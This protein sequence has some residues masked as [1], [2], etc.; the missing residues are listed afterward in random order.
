MARLTDLPVVN[1]PLADLLD[2][3]NFWC[4]DVVI[5]AD[6]ANTVD[7]EYGPKGAVDH[8]LEPGKSSI[9][10]ARNLKSFM[11]KALAASQGLRVSIVRL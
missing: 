1:T 5:Q 4:D 8:F 6:K 11:V 2:S 7:I 9:Y 3:T 10:P